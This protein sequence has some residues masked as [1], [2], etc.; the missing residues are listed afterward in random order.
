[1]LRL[2]LTPKQRET[3]AQLRCDRS[4]QPLERDRVEM[5][6]LADK[7][8]RAPA[9]ADHLDY[10]PN[11]VRQVLKWVL[12]DGLPSLRLKPMGR[13]VDVDRRTEITA[14]LTR[15]LREPRTWSSRQLAAVLCEEGLLLSGRQVRRYLHQFGAGYHCQFAQGKAPGHRGERAPRER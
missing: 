14:V 5:V 4:L 1:M 8:W 6:R 11:T 7:G 13:P 15:H 9:I 2:T 12:A 3:L 10:H